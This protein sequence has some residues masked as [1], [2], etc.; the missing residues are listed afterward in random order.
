MKRTG[1]QLENIKPGARSLAL[2][3][4]LFPRNLAALP[5]TL[6]DVKDDYI[7]WIS[8]GETILGH[9]NVRSSSYRTLVDLL[10]DWL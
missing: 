2:T 5:Y 1:G 3:S 4:F 6:S 7:I 8:P 10:T 9:T